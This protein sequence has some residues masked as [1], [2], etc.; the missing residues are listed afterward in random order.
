ML[1]ISSC[2]QEYAL[3]IFDQLEHPMVFCN[4]FEADDE[5]FLKRLITRLKGQKLKTVQELQR[6]NFRI[7]AVGNS[8]NDIDMI[9]AAEKGVLFRPSEAVKKDHPEIPV[10]TSYDELKKCIAQVVET[11]EPNSKKQKT[12]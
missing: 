6:L 5:G 12:G 7:L 3:P 9:H 2:A 11:V 4:F 10:V 1:S 8:F